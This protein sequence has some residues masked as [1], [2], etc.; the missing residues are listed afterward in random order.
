MKNGQ[1]GR[2]R[3]TSCLPY[4]KDPYNFDFLTLGPGAEEWEL[5]LVRSRCS[6]IHLFLVVKKRGILLTTRYSE[7]GGPIVLWSFWNS[8]ISR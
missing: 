1:T 4:A 3:I 2:N 7:R 5:G 8:C 6:P